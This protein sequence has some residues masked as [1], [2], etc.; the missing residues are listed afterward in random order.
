MSPDE[1]SIPNKKGEPWRT[2]AVPWRSELATALLRALDSL[3][4][5]TEATR[6]PPQAHRS[7]QNS[8]T[9][10]AKQQRHLLKRVWA[11]MEDVRETWNTVKVSG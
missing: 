4:P 1:D 9:P 5:V 6:A 10:D 3:A 7:S 11:V 2:L 8:A